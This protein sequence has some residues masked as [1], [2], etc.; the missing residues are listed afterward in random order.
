MQNINF[1]NELNMQNIKNKKEL[2]RSM[3]ELSRIHN[4]KPLLNKESK[5]K[6]KYLEKFNQ[7]YPIYS[8]KIRD[9]CN[10][11][12]KQ[13]ENKYFDKVKANSSFKVCFSSL[14][15]LSDDFLLSQTKT[16]VQKE[17]KLNIE[18]LQHLQEIESRKLYLERG[19]S[20]LFD[21]AVRE[22]GYSRGSA[23]R[24]IK[25]MKL[26]Q[27]IPETKSQLESG[28]LNLS[29][30][31]Q[32]QN[33]FEKQARKPLKQEL[34][35]DNFSQQ[36]TLI[37]FSK[38]QQLKNLQSDESLFQSNIKDRFPNKEKT[39]QTNFS[40]N[41]CSDSF[42]A[43]PHCSAE[44]KE[45]NTSSVNKGSSL[46]KNKELL[47]KADKTKD[48][49]NLRSDSFCAELDCSAK[50]KEHNASSVKQGL[51]LTKK[52]EL[53]EKAQ[54][55]STRDI[56]KML[57]ETD[58]FHVSYHKEKTRFIGNQKV[59]FKVILDEDC[60]KNLETLKNLLSHTNPRMSYRELI[61]LL[62][63]LG[64]KKY[65][66]RKKLNQKLIKQENQKA[67]CSENLLK[68]EQNKQA[69]FNK[70]LERKS[71]EECNNTNLNLFN[72]K[73]DQSS[74]KKSLKKN[75]I[76][77]KEPF[78]KVT[79]LFDSKSINK[80]STIMNSKITLSHTNL[81]IQLFN[82]QE[83]QS[84]SC[85]PADDFQLRKN[86]TNKS[87]EK[88]TTQ[89]ENSFDSYKNFNK[90]KIKNK[91][92]KNNRYIP[93]KIRQYIWNRDKGVC[94]YVCPKTQNKCRSKHLLQIDHIQPFALG[95]SH[96]PNNLR[97]LC[98][99]HNQLRSQRTFGF[100]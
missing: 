98:A 37:E 5:D 41:L 64:L 3:Q 62:A 24:R 49:S 70:K 57:V 28:K 2:N 31:S 35:K 78:V 86:T 59:E 92:K 93:Q 75:E 66:P 19:F 40:S 48:L 56:E 90:P 91:P 69:Q 8:K 71:K 9:V 88:N 87:E 22:L 95:G 14:K 96:H 52:K 89:D 55:Q 4:K 47:A 43:E 12:L 44:T 100:K 94:S 80:S 20:S 18:I 39:D 85:L 97:L 7:A 74:I 77:P 53:L 54:G 25:A 46:T 17:R 42:C 11:N 65:D 45:H 83:N 63:E 30:A 34:K 68:A 13:E 58:S 38:Q 36:Q 72:N 81:Q 29:S 23:F 21:Y 27:D 6:E 99:E 10:K 82:N 26:C 50:T 16:L 84:S 32:L 60:F 1:N 51:S 61:G 76:S 33:F 15:K 79:E 73:E 67:L